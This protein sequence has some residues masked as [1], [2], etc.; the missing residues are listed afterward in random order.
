[1]PD[2]IGRTRHSFGWHTACTSPIPTVGMA[3]VATETSRASAQEDR[4]MV[5][6]HFEDMISGKT[7]DL[8]AQP[9]EFSTGSTGFWAG[10]KVEIAGE[11]YQV[12][13]NVV[14]IGSKPKLS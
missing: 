3:P 2:F 11:R 14:L 6:V 10:G 12:S 8:V 4:D 7:S 1:V 9:K 13:C 5:L